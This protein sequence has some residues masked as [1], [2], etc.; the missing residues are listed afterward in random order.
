MLGRLGA[1]NAFSSEGCPTDNIFSTMGL[2]KHHPQWKLRSI[3]SHF[4]GG[5]EFSL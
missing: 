1:L 2:S 5:L 3:C 4:R